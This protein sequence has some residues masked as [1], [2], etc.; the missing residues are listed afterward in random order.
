MIW[1]KKKTP[2]VDPAELSQKAD[3]ALE[4]V[5]AQQPHVN[6]LTNWLERRKNQNGFGADFEYALRPKGTR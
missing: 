6:T 3:A 4:Q 5:R 1:R 2:R